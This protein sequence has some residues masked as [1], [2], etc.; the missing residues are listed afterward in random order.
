MLS[1]VGV[2]YLFVFR[3]LFIYLFD[4]GV[5]NFIW[6]CSKYNKNQFYGGET[7]VIFLLTNC[8]TYKETFLPLSLMPSSSVKSVSFCDPISGSSTYLPIRDIVQE[9]AFYLQKEI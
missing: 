2:S 3:V 1:T 6:T 7:V 4:V 5:S 8:E 9:H